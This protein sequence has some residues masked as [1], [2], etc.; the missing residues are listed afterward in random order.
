MPVLS[1]TYKIIVVQN[2]HITN[3]STL[4]DGS[5]IILLDIFKLCVCVFYVGMRT[6]VQCLERP[7]EGT[8]APATG[9]NS[10]YEPLA[11]GAGS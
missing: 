4:N 7:E 10:G 1:F 9:V 5:S 3:V 11:V 2:D 6:W 8:R